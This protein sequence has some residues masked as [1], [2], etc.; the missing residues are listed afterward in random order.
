MRDELE[1]AREH[2]QSLLPILTAERAAEL[3]DRA[4]RAF[5]DEAGI[6]PDLKRGWAVLE[7]RRREREKVRAPLP[8]GGCFLLGYQAIV[9][10][11]L[12]EIHSIL[13]G[14]LRLPPSAIRLRLERTEKLGLRKFRPVADFEIPD[15]WVLPVGGEVAQKVLG[16]GA[17][18]VDA[19]RAFIEKALCA[20]EGHYYTILRERLE[21]ADLVRVDVL[22]AE[23]RWN[24]KADI[25]EATSAISGETPVG[26][27]RIDHGRENGLSDRSGS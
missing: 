17:S 20:V 1:R 26:T 5:F 27:H 2:A 22:Q 19:P 23:G 21:A 13:C 15:D 12:A 3:R 11:C 14:W 4:A 16:A 8:P 9:A 18:A 6:P 10:G 24:E 7:E 25:P